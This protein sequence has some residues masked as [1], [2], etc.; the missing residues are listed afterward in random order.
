MAPIRNQAAEPAAT[1]PP[2]AAST[3]AIHE[4]LP[5]WLVTLL[6]DGCGGGAVKEAD[7]DPA[8][9]TCSF[10]GTSEAASEGD[11]AG[12]RLRVLGGEVEFVDL[13]W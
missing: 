2:S 12:R 10:A 13:V 11:I 6:V 8:S 3:F 4:A 1:A 9:A 5:T 7:F